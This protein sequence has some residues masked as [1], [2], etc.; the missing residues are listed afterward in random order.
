ML[1][2]DGLAFGDFEVAEVVVPDAFGGLAFGEEDE[3]GFDASSGAGEDAAGEAEDAPDVGFVEKF[4]FGLDE[5]FFV[6][7]EEDA[8]VEDDAAATVG[9][10][11][12]EDVLDEEDL[13]GAGFVVEAIANFLTL[14]PPKG[15]IH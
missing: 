2:G 9:F 5:G 10:E 4:A 14:F 3:V 8:F 11:A 6:G 7:A 13:G 15:R 1:E 12:V